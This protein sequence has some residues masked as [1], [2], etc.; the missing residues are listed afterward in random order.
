MKQG[1][2][3][4]LSH[5][6]C[7][8]HR[9]LQRPLRK[10]WIK[11]LPILLNRLQSLCQLIGGCWVTWLKSDMTAVNAS[12]PL[13]IYM[14]RINMCLLWGVLLCCVQRAS[15][16]RATWAARPRAQTTPRPSSMSWT[17]VQRG[18]VDGT[19]SQY[20]ADCQ[21]TQHRVALRSPVW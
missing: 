3:Q 6:S 10:P 21:P 12:R 16:G 20:E 15:T 17:D 13:R 11:P 1:S 9:L 14:C 4:L 7:V 5:H 8:Q 19:C 18:T 2:G